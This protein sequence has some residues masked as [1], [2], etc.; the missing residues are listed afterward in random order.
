MSDG[1]SR[2]W[3]SYWKENMQA[4]GFPVPD[5]WYSTEVSILTLTSAIVG[6]IEKFGPRVTV[7]EVVK[8]GF[9]SERL[10]AFGAVSAAYFAGASI[11]SAAVATGRTLSGG[12]SLADIFFYASRNNV[13]SSAT[14]Q[15]LIRHPQIYNQKFPGRFAYARQIARP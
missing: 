4:L 13:S 7:Y 6:A 2:S 14:R 12:T 15:V 5:T 3:F 9:A 10:M 8:A 11:G 1:Q